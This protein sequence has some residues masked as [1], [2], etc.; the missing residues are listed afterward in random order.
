MLHISVFPDKII[1]LNNPDN[2]PVHIML[3]TVLTDD[4]INLFIENSIFD[5]KRIT[6]ACRSVD[7]FNSLEKLNSIELSIINIQLSFWDQNIYK[8]QNKKFNF[9]IERF[10]LYFTKSIDK[11]YIKNCGTILI[12]GGEVKRIKIKNIKHTFINNTRINILYI[13]NRTCLN[14]KSCSIGYYL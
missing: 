9:Y 13:R 4:I 3:L 1:N 14:I 5:T 8:I 6:F 10:E 7:I 12:N 11:I 2:E